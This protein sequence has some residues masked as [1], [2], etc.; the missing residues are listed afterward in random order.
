VRGANEKQ[1]TKKNKNMSTHLKSKLRVWA[2]LDRE[3]MAANAARVG[4]VEGAITAEQSAGLVTLFRDVAFESVGAIWPERPSDI[5]ILVVSVDAASPDDLSRAVRRLGDEPKSG[6]V[7]VVLRNADVATTRAIVHAGAADVLPAPFGEA[8][9]ALC[10][11]RLLARQPRH[12]ET[13]GK[14]G[15]VIALLKA[16]GGVGATSVA[17]QMTHLLAARL[18]TAGKVCFADLDLQF[19]AAA[20]YFDLQDPLSIT[21]CLALGE[22]LGET[23]F[24]SMLAAHKSGVRVLAGPRD[25]TPLDA[26]TPTAAESLIAGLRRDFAITVVDLPSVWTVWTNRVL[27]LCD[28]IVLVTNLS[29]AHVHLTRRQLSVLKLQKLSDLPLTLVCNAVTAEQQ[30]MLPVKNAEKAI[31]RPFDVVLPADYAAM[32]AATNEGLMLSAVRRG[33]KLEKAVG[34]FAGTMAAS[35]QAGKPAVI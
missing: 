30:N 8:A 7:L 9:L 26:V 23:Q 32:G 14:S 3:N 10:L 4:I 18:G 29:V 34:Q 25:L 6:Q 5:D 19:G 28:R 22:Q 13:P 33:T 21:E 15:Q 16:G 17:V 2:G 35:V 12:A 31:G 1:E 24:L 11:E 20:L 27:Q